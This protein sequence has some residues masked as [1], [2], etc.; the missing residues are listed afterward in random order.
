MTGPAGPVAI[1]P[2]SASALTVFMLC[3]FAGIMWVIAWVVRPCLAGFIYADLPIGANPLALSLAFPLALLLSRI[4]P[5]HNHDFLPPPVGF[6]AR[7][8]PPGPWDEWGL[9]RVASGL[10][11]SAAECL[12]RPRS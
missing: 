4:P 5:H 8:P 11:L 6:A 9:E 10:R 2:T 1:P 7:P 12:R 3:L